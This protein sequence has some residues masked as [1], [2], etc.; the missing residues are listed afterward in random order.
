[1]LFDI[2]G[3]PEESI[4]Y[5]PC[6]FIY[7]F[8][9]FFSLFELIMVSDVVIMITIACCKKEI[10]AISELQSTLND[11]E[12]SKNSAGT[13]IRRAHEAHLVLADKASML[14]MFFWHIYFYK[15]F[16]I[17]LYLCTMSVGLQG[18]NGIFPYG[19]AISVF[20][21]MLEAFLLCYFGQTLKD[22]SEKMSDAIYMSKWYEMNVKDQKNLVI[23]MIRLQHQ[24]QV[25]TFG[26][27]T[28]SIYTFVQVSKKEENH[29]SGTFRTFLESR[30]SK[31][32]E[33]LRALHYLSDF[34]SD[35]RTCEEQ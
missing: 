7:Q 24:V 1:M 26:F 10:D 12:L 8:L 16:S 14:K 5:Y 30:F 34:T 15:L 6:N 17:L 20:V 11:E 4:F 3:I 19:A 9:L 22:S 21:M 32:T 29:N 35:M 31:T 23:I 28:I 13:I 18:L 2:P 27:G 25:E 33:K